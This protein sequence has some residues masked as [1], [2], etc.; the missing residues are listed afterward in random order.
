VINNLGKTLALLQVGLSLA[1]AALALAIYFNAVDFGW[2]QPA[3]YFSEAKGQKGNNLLVPSL[4]DKRE[5][6]M[7]KLVRIKR[8][9]LTRLDGLQEDSAAVATILGKNHLLGNQ[10]LE[11][12]A[13]GEGTMEIKGV[14][15]NENGEL[16]VIAESHPEL[17]FP[18][19]E[20]ALPGINMSYAG[21][22]AKLKELDSRIEEKQ[23]STDDLLKKEKD[24]TGRLSGRIEKDGKHAVDKS[25][26]VI[27]PGWL[28]LLETEYQAQAQLL[29]E[30]EYVQPLWVKE[31]VDSQQV[32]SRRDSLLRRLEELGDK[33]YL[34]QSEFLKRR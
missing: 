25:G 1:L 23:A 27:E 26:S 28:Y 17:A 34:S 29:K 18:A 19:L 24:V 8:D 30:L 7:R 21:Y 2:E 10:V 14:R 5:A 4:F 9:E 13:Q 20:T 12:L 11:Q 3:R 16:A 33:G 31:L 6:A 32:L 15:Y 22:L